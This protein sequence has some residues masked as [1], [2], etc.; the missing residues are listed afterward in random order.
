MKSIITIPVV[1]LA[2]GSLVLLTGCNQCRESVD[3]EAPLTIDTKYGQPTGISPDT[4]IFTAGNI[5]VTVMEFTTGGANRVFDYA[6]IESSPAGFTG[7]QVMRFNNISV[8][9]FFG[10]VGFPVSEV[11][12]DYMDMGGTESLSTGAFQFVGEIIDAPSAVVAQTVSVTSSTIP[13]G[14][15]GTVTITGTN[16]DKVVI[17]G[18]EFWIDNLCVK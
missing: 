11:S 12:F 16:I 15:R 1:A 6:A 9:F 10:N 14:K 4:Q 7:T 2:L 8:H 18:Q 5:Q 3:F 17:G 13:G